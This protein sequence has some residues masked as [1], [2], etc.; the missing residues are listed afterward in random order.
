MT[1]ESE[2]YGHNIVITKKARVKMKD[3]TVQIARHVATLRNAAVIA[4]YTKIEKMAHGL[5]NDAFAGATYL[6]PDGLSIINDAHL[7]NSTGESFDNKLS[8]GTA[9]ATSVLDAVAAYG[10]AFT[11]SHGNEM[12]LNF[13]TIVCK[14]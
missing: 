2:E 3:D 5:L 13:R 8:T 4:L 6:A 14:K 9:P 11:D 10:G 12:P 1:Q 7:W